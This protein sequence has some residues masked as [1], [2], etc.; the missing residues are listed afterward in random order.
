MALVSRSRNTFEM[1]RRAINVTAI[2]RAR[3]CREKRACR[4]GLN[5]GKMLSEGGGGEGGKKGRRAA[6]IGQRP[7]RGNSLSAIVSSRRG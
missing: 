5:L 3:A 1:I 7:V 2:R 4:M 6:E